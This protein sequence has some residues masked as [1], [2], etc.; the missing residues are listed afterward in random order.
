MRVLRNVP[1]FT[2]IFSKAIV[3]GFYG[4]STG[5]LRFSSVFLGNLTQSAKYG[6]KMMSF[7]RR[8]ARAAVT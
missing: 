3:N 2:I 8:P 6:V 5:F 7:S 1:H 4:V